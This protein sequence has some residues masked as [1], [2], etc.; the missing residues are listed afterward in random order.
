MFKLK[1]SGNHQKHNEGVSGEVGHLLLLVVTFKAVLWSSPHLC[2]GPCGI[3]LDAFRETLN[4]G[5]RLAVRQ[6][7]GIGAGKDAL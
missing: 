6:L 3:M 5:A 7:R 4:R 2:P 1:I